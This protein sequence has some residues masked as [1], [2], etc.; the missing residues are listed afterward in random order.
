[1]LIFAPII[2][3]DQ[4]TKY[5]V[6]KFIV[7]GSQI[8]VMPFLNIV[9]LKNTGI[10]FG[11]FQGFN[12]LLSVISA[13]VLAVIT[14]WF[15]FE[16]R[17][18]GKLFNISFALILSGGVSNYFDRAYFGFVTDFIDFYVS[19]Y[20]WYTFNI[21]DASISIGA[22]LLAYYYLF[23]KKHTKKEKNVSNII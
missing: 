23:I 15:I 6:R 17:T 11:M 5:F 20:H 3:L 22:F 13:I 18:E 19:T 8:D 2:L 12:Q 16:S 9:Y 14:F 7:L 1:M 10:A 4:F 21:A